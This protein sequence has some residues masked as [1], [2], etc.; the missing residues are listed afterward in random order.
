[1]HSNDS[2]TYKLHIGVFLIAK[3]FHN[4]INVQ[5]DYCKAATLFIGCSCDSEAVTSASQNIF[6]Y[7]I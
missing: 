4:N 6:R 5:L 2:S 1:M 7:H 3:V